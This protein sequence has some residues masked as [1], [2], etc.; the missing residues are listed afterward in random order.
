MPAPKMAISSCGAD[1]MMTAILP[2]DMRKLPNTAPEEHANADEL[3]HEFTVPIWG[4][5]IAVN[6]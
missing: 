3:K 4:L 1:S 2:P 5:S 6:A